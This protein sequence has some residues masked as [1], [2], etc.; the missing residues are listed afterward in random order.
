[1]VKL[2]RTYKAFSLVESLVG[3]IIILITFSIGIM[4]F[5]EVMLSSNSRQRI[6]ADL[7]IQKTIDETI[8]KNEFIDQ[9][10]ATGTYTIEKKVSPYKSEKNLSILEIKIFN[11]DKKLVASQKKLVATL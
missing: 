4:I 7:L 1:V 9:S 5:N 8:E 3:M 10:I 11:A 2:K 6:H